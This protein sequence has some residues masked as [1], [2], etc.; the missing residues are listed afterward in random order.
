MIEF[1]QKRFAVDIDVGVDSEIFVTVD[2][3]KL[4]DTGT[5]QQVGKTLFFE[6]GGFAFLRV[7]ASLFGSIDATDTDG[8]ILSGD[9][10]MFVDV[11]GEGI[12]VDEAKRGAPHAPHQGTAK[13]PLKNAKGSTKTQWC[14]PFSNDS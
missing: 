9:G 14:F 12:A 4:D 10:G 7:F 3:S 5:I 2:I 1:R 13:R 6:V 11:T 8:N